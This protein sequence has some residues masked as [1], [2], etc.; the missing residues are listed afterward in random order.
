MKKKTKLSISLISA[1]SSLA[2][3]CSCFNNMISNST[4]V[5]DPVVPTSISVFGPEQVYL[6]QE[7]VQYSVIVE[8]EEAEK[9]VRWE[10]SDSKIMT[11]DF[12]GNAKP[13]NAGPVTIKAISILSDNVF[14]ELS[15]NVVDLPDPS[16]I[17]IVGPEYVYLH[18][19]PSYTY[20]IETEPEEAKKEV[21]WKVENIDGEAE[22]EEDG[23][24]KPKKAGRV[25]VKATSVWSVCSYSLEVLIYP[26]I[27][28]SLTIK[29]RDAL[30]TSTTS[31]YS[32]ITDPEEGY[33]GVNW[34]VSDETLATIDETGKLTTNSEG[35]T[36]TVTIT[37]TCSAEPS[38]IATK[39]VLI[40]DDIVYIDVSKT[41]GHG[42]DYNGS[43]HSLPGQDAQINFASTTYKDDD[44]W[45]IIH[46][47][48][49]PKD[50]EVLVPTE[51]DAM[52]NIIDHCTLE[53]NNLII[54][55]SEIEKGKNIVI[56]ILGAELSDTLTWD[57]IAM[58]AEKD[59]T[60]KEDDTFKYTAQY[61]QVG[62]Y[63]KGYSDGK[64]IGEFIIV[65]E[66]HDYYEK[67]IGERK[68]TVSIPLT[69]MPKVLHVEK[70]VRDAMPQSRWEKDH[71]DDYDYLEIPR[72]TYF[73][74]DE[75]QPGGRQYSKAACVLRKDISDDKIDSLSASSIAVPMKKV[76]PCLYDK[77]DTYY[78]QEDKFWAPSYQEVYSI[79]FQPGYFATMYNPDKCLG[80]ELDDDATL[81]SYF[82]KDKYAFYNDGYDR[83]PYEDR[84][85]SDG[86]VD[87]GILLRTTWINKEKTREYEGDMEFDHY[88][89]GCCRFI[90]ETGEGLTE[91]RKRYV[92]TFHPTPAKKLYKY[93]VSFCI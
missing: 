50:L 21:K 53:H 40:N 85:Y 72:A 64:L 81:Y 69:F 92:N 6:D 74:H 38:I 60:K 51:D 9:Q 2:L 58:I 43:D 82:D 91:I 41:I 17:S 67:N 39:E 77:T 12:N 34:S 10:S 80:W 16:S 83:I 59:H 20:T 65:D 18:K 88:Q 7:T 27:P 56:N 19:Q 22:I 24:L 63:K 61:F 79:D 78:R 8:P 75:D 87:V 86:C 3:C 52:E 57:D 32:V 26:E 1:M 70:A 29:G 42:F 13:V 28:K 93:G 45:F 15:V 5:N 55:G 71:G 76:T 4:D 30:H 54:P 68:V 47:E 11:I 37:A 23:S 31:Q 44:N 49:K 35:K 14:G 89:R 62:D 66:Y 25:I 48:L 84:E 33:D 73:W 46:N 90:Y 36:G